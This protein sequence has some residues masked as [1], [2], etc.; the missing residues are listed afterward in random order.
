MFGYD[1]IGLFVGFE[2][3][4]GIVIEIILRI[5][6]FFELVCVFLVG[7]FIIESIG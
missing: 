2:G 7:F 5:F 1:L 6:K 4:L 3:I